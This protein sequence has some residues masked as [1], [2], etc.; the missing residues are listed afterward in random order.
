M[1]LTIVETK[2]KTLEEIGEI[3]DSKHP[4]RESLRKR[5]VI[6]KKGEGVKLEEPTAEDA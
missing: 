6:I 3:F 2:G 5:E 1:Y 4:V